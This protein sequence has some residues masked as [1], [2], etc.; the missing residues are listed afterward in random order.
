MKKIFLI[1]LS[2]AFFQHLESQ[3][4]L[5]NSYIVSLNN[6]TIRG[7]II[8]QTE[9]DFSKSINF[10]KISE[11]GKFK[12]YKPDEIKEFGFEQNYIYRSFRI[13][14][15]DIDTI[16]KF[17]FLRAIIVGNTS[18]YRI[19]NTKEEDGNQDIGLSQF[20]YFLKINNEDIERL[21][22][23][24]NINSNRTE[25]K[26]D[27]R[28]KGI[29][30][31]RMHGCPELVK[32][33][34]RCSYIEP[35]L[36]N[37]VKEFNK[38][39]NQNMNNSQVVQEIDLRKGKINYGFEIFGGIAMTNVSNIFTTNED[40]PT[41]DISVIGHKIEIGASG[42]ISKGTHNKL[43]LSLSYEQLITNKTID[44][45]PDYKLNFDLKFLSTSITYGYYMNYD[46]YVPF[47]DGGI[48]I[49]KLIVDKSKVIAQYYN[50][51]PLGYIYNNY[52]I[53]YF[54][55]IGI[56]KKYKSISPFISIYFK[57]NHFLAKDNIL[58]NLGLRI[59]MSF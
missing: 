40:F 15:S 1:V 47:V 32:K 53:F 38:C 54:A 4:K 27:N 3:V 25:Y 30:I 43:K 41:N 37:L 8:D 31:Y 36:V 29:L 10:A 18:L 13:C 55:N 16:K 21:P 24:E 57:D 6:D 5:N 45:D 48:Y 34:E 44:H 51:A 46:K 52:S 22:Y 12:L 56:Y 50:E 59:G 19:T 2:F 58:T 11:P 26:P 23:K 49:N 39:N 33:I 42:T 7:F 20:Q 14:L 9:K 17:R 35:Q 28:Y